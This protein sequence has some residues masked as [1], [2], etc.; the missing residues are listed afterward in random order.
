MFTNFRKCLF[1]VA[2]ACAALTTLGV[3]MAHAG[4]PQGGH[5]NGLML[6]QGFT[7]DPPP[8]GPLAPFQPVD[9]RPAPLLP[10]EIGTN[11]WPPPA[12]LPTPQPPNVNGVP[13]FLPRDTNNGR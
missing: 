3:T 13:I 12:P 7:P 10:P 9:P 6:A 8:G 11:T 1:I 2:I 5:L 4:A